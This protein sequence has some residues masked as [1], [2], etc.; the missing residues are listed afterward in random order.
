MAHV[1]QL[2]AS[3]AE[4]SAEIGSRGAHGQSFLVEPVFSLM[5]GGPAVANT[6]RCGRNS[7]VICSTEAPGH[8]LYDNSAVSHPIP[9]TWGG[10]IAPSLP[11]P[12]STSIGRLVTNDS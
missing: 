7:S 11:I 10:L 9:G 1:E 2:E 5:R 4:V 3:I 8:R 6:W 12:D